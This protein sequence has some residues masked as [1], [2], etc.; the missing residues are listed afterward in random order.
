MRELALASFLPEEVVPP[1]NALRELA[2]RMKSAVKSAGGPKWNPFLS[3][4]LKRC[5]C[6]SH[7]RD[8]IHWGG[9][10]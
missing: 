8:A 1:I 9:M 6:D 3:V 10:L 7:T 2:T 5:A 4:E